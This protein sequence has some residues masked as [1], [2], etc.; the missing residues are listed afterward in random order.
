[1]CR[2]SASAAPSFIWQPNWLT[3]ASALA[4]RCERAALRKDNAALTFLG[5]LQL[6]QLREQKRL[7]SKREGEQTRARDAYRAMSRYP[8]GTVG[9]PVVLEAEGEGEEG[10]VIA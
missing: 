5:E 9:D 10:A 8:L 2:S 4:L 6:Q 7:A 1:M 3:A